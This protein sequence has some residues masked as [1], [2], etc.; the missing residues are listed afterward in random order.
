MLAA[1]GI[2]TDLTLANADELATARLLR[3]EAVNLVEEDRPLEAI[4][5]LQEAR[6]KISSI[7]EEAN[8]MIIDIKL[9]NAGRPGFELTTS[10]KLEVEREKEAE[11]FRESEDEPDRIYRLDC[12]YRELA[13]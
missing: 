2:W 6:W 3:L 10:E 12:E 1:Q 4:Q 9:E 11:R 7:W 5:A 13:P 8:Q